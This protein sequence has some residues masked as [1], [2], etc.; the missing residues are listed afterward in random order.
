[1]TLLQQKW[2]NDVGQGKTYSHTFRFHVNDTGHTLIEPLTATTSNAALAKAERLAF[3][4]G[5]IQ[6]LW[7]EYRKV[8]VLDDIENKAELWIGKPSDA[9]QGY[10]DEVIR[11]SRKERLIEVLSSS[12]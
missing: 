12:R 2:E 7:P 3:R 5:D 10:S 11:W 4:W 8:T 9:L 1:L 6:A